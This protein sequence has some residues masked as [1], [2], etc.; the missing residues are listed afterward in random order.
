V[1]SAEDADPQ[2]HRQCHSLGH[3]ENHNV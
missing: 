1:A 2:E 3:S